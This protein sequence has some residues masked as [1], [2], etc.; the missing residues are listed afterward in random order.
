MVNNFTENGNGVSVEISFYYDTGYA[1]DMFNE[2]VKRYENN[3]DEFF[4]TDFGN[5]EGHELDEMYIVTDETRDKVI[6]EIMS[7]NEEATKKG[8]GLATNEELKRE[9]EC[10]IDFDYDDE[11]FF[12]FDHENYGMIETR[13]YSQGDYAKVYYHKKELRELW[14]IDIDEESLKEQVGKVFWDSP[15]C[16]NATIKGKE[17]R[18][19]EFL[20][21]EYLGNDDAREE[22]LE[23]MEKKLKKREF[24]AFNELFEGME[25]SYD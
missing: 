15:I 20:S 12:E 1:Q 19:D 25:A 24:E 10:W 9:L 17:Y 4:Y 6:A 3:H 2:S 5:V 22:I 11:D 13:G 16:F 14:G 23:Y 8:L 18:G 7:N 21:S